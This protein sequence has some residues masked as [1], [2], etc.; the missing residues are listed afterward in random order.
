MGFLLALLGVAL[1][2]YALLAA[3]EGRAL[4]RWTALPMLALFLAAFIIISTGVTGL[5]VGKIFEQV[6]GRPLFVVDKTTQAG[7]TVEGTLHPED[8]PSADGATVTPV[9]SQSR[10]EAVP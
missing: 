1:A 2:G 4:P 8:A 6:K 3:I 10:R 9:P 7:V 5:Y